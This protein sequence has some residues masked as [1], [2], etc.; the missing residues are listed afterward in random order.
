MIYNAYFSVYAWG[1]DEK[2]FFNQ[3]I[4]QIQEENQKITRRIK[5]K[6][7]NSEERKIQLD[8]YYRETVTALVHM[9][10]TIPAFR[11]DPESICVPLGISYRKLTDENEKLEKLSLVTRL[12]PSI[13]P[14]PSE[15]P[16]ESR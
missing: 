14:W 1:R 12:D 8:T 7:V 3:K 10:L 4:R 5:A 2:N 9:Y 16:P 15:N 11:N 6:I 13:A